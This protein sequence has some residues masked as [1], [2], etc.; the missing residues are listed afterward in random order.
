MCQDK[1]AFILPALEP[2]TGRRAPLDQLLQWADHSVTGKTL[3]TL[4]SVSGIRH[5]CSATTV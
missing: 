5:T 3:H 1:A 4:H 2:H